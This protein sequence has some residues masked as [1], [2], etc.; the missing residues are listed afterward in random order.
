MEGNNGMKKRRKDGK[1]RKGNRREKECKWLQ[2]ER[3]EGMKEKK[4]NKA[5]WQR[6]VEIGNSEMH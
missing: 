5:K 2:E 3:K 1:E 4:L 6:R